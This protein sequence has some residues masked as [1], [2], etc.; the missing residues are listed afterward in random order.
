MALQ[1]GVDPGLQGQVI[2]YVIDID[3]GLDHDVDGGHGGDE[4][5]GHGGHVDGGD[6]GAPCTMHHGSTG[7]SGHRGSRAG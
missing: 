4:A 7:E 2:F 3:S 1:G 6:G 5:G